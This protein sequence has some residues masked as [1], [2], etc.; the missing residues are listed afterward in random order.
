[1][2]RDHEEVRIP[3]VEWFLIATFIG[4][5]IGIIYYDRAHNFDINTLPMAGDQ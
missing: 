5:A 3:L 1:M 2:K 4:L